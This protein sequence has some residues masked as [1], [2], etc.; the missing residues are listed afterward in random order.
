MQDDYKIHAL[1]KE[2]ELLKNM[3]DRASIGAP[4]IAVFEKLIAEAEIKL[5][6][7]TKGELD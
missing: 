4:T 7:L 2:L 5:H 3:L 6:K 1:K